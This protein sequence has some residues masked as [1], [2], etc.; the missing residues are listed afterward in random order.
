VNTIV[1]ILSSF[2]M[3]LGVYCA[4][5]SRRTGLIICLMLTL[6]GAFGFMGI[7][8]VEYRDKWRHGLLW[9]VHYQPSE[10]AG[11]H[12]ADAHS[13]APDKSAAATGAGD[14]SAPS[15]VPAQTAG[16][17]AAEHAPA[18]PVPVAAP[19][20]DAAS[21][22]APGPKIE[23]STIAPA[24]RSPAGLAVLTE[25]EK[26]KNVHLFF[27][28]YFTMTGLHGLHVLA[29]IVVIF[30]LLINAFNGRYNSEYYTPVDL[31]G[32]YWHLVDLVWIFLFPLLYLIH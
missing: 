26:A 22:A 25:D 4:Q 8:Y 14:H 12:Q 11:A 24:A 29:G 7:K 17:P 16:G 30:A 13:G 9:G 19:P 3:A 23:K 1:L 32:L 31:V 6:L 5:T 18:V 10:H 20:A 28:I 27:G 2:T 15:A 21:T